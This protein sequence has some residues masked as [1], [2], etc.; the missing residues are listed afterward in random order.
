MTIRRMNDP[1][2][3]R[4]LRKRE[5]AGDVEIRPK[6][7]RELQKYAELSADMAERV[8]NGYNPL[9]PK[10]GI[11]AARCLGL[12]TPDAYRT[13]RDCCWIGMEKRCDQDTLC[14]QCGKETQLLPVP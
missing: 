10:V 6:L 3:L 7:R 9:L 4:E 12:P 2:W 1:K 14:P 8:L 13:C 11:A 5:A